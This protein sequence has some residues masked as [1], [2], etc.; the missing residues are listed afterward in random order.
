MTS[1][2]ADDK[3]W[4]KGSVF[5]EDSITIEPTTRFSVLS[6]DPGAGKHHAPQ[7]YAPNWVRR[8]DTEMGKSTGKLIDLFNEH[9]GEVGFDD[10]ADSLN[11]ISKSM[12]LYGSA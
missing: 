12:R 9:D 4:T 1:S 7:R 6:L 2:I 11:A 5:L 3:S 10:F 8:I